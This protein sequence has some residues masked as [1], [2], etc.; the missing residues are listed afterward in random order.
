[1][2]VPVAARTKAWVCGRSP[3]GI[4]RS[5]PAGDHGCLSVVSVVC[6]QVPVTSRSLGQSSPTDCGVSDCDNEAS[7]MI[8][9]WPSGG[10]LRHGKLNF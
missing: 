2:P 9:P 8:R 6:C 7:I 5:K 3:T 10:L 4:L 1:M